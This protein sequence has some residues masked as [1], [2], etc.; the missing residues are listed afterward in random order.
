MDFIFGL[1]IC[2]GFW[3]LLFF[4]SWIMQDHV[5]PYYRKVTSA[6]NRALRGSIRKWYKIATGRGID[7][8]P[9]NCALCLRYRRKTI[10]AFGDERWSSCSLECPVL[11]KTG[12]EN[13]QGSPYEDFARG[14]IQY[15]WPQDRP[16]TKNTALEIR[17]S[18][19]AEYAFLKGLL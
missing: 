5:M 18:A 15:G 13:C 19:W 12:R 16:L 1:L 14:L 2:G 7:Q 6:R 8:G 11:I 3:I 10:G 17:I 9:G 4:G